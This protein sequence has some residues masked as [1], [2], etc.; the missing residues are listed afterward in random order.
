MV[1]GKLCFA[2]TPFSF[3]SKSLVS[4]TLS[5]IDLTIVLF[6]TAEV[7]IGKLDMNWD[8]GTGEKRLGLTC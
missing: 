5:G 3:N 8:G 7:A 6:L 1:F 2:V 4:P